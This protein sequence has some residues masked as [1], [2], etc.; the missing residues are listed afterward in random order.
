MIPFTSKP[1]VSVMEKGKSLILFLLLTLCVPMVS[2]LEQSSQQAIQTDTPTVFGDEKPGKFQV[3]FYVGCD[4][5]AIRSQ[6]ADCVSLGLT[7][8]PGAEL[9]TAYPKYFIKINALVHECGSSD[10]P[11]KIVALA[12]DLTEQH[13]C[14][15]F[16]RQV[17]M[18]QG[19]LWSHEK[20][21]RKSLDE[22]A[23]NFKGCLA[24]KGLV[25]L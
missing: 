13:S 1:G 10:Y 25:K 15:G 19:M 20:E 14:G 16:P 24:R 23:A 12:Y 7:Q 11:V 21:L 18:Q 6:I 17:L 9:A 2:C 4:D 5:D 22:I 8:I 3:G